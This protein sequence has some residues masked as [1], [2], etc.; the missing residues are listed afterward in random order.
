MWIQ[1]LY[2]HYVSTVNE[3]WMIYELY[4]LYMEFI[5]VM[6]TLDA[7]LLWAFLDY[8]KMSIQASF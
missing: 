2:L 3:I 8:M 4:G 1:I 7:S 5:N 6:G